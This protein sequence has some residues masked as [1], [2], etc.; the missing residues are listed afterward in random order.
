LGAWL[1]GQ[2][3]WSILFHVPSFS[4]AILA[5]AAGVM[6]V[7]CLVACLLPSDRA[8]RVSPVEALA[9]Q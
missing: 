7:V 1:T 4:I 3:M 9:D 6:G 2:T 8:A 5:G